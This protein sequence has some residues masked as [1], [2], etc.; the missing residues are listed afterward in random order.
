MSIGTLIPHS[1]PIRKGKTQANSKI[2][3]ENQQK[4]AVLIQESQLFQLAVPTH[5]ITKP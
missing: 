2:L 3:A 1:L 4:L 5:L